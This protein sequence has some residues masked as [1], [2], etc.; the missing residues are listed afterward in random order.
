MDGFERRKEQSKEEIR[1][2]AWELFSQFGVD[3]VSIADIARKAGISQATI[4]NN[5]GNKDA[6]VREFVGGS[7]KELVTRAEEVLFPNMTYRTK[8]ATFLQFIAGM[9]TSGQSSNAKTALRSVSI[10]IQN[11]PEIKKIREAAREKMI[12][13]MLN[14]VAEGRQQGDVALN[15]SNEALSIYFE[16]FMEIFSHPELQI[17]YNQYP[18][19]V[20]EL[21]R[22][23]MFGLKGEY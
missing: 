11:D 20:Q 16:A 3:R 4:Y 18:D 2:A 23:M 8:M 17:R 1:K 21:G 19:I 5:F 10:D 9:M 12:G 6:I 13:M 7:V 15:L 22:L 14:L